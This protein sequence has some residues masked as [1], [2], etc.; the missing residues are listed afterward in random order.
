MVLLVGAIVLLALVTAAEAAVISSNRARLRLLA[1][2]G[3]SRSQILARYLQE[4]H[5][6]YSS[7]ALARNFALIGSTA[8][9]V[10]IVLNE[11]GLN[12]AVL[13]VTFFVA[14]A[15]LAVIQAI[16]RLVVSRN[17][18]RWVAY[19][20]RFVGLVRL[21]F[22]LP[23][24]VLDLP[25]RAI[26][27]WRRL[28]V[29]GTEA[30][31]ETEEILRLLEMEESAGLIDE[32]ERRMIR[33]VMALED[34]TAREIM[35]PR[36]DIVA[37]ASDSSF[38]DIAH[39]IVERGYSRI[40]VFED[41]ID[42]IVGVVYA[43][44]VLDYLANSAKPADVKGMARP[45]YFVPESKKV[46]ELLTE[47]R[48]NK[49]SIA[50]V[51]DE[52]GGT[53]GLVTIEDLIEEIVGEIADEFDVE[54]EPIHRVS[55][56]EAILDARVSIDALQELFGVEVE[57]GDFDTVGGFVFNHL[58][59]MPSVGEEIRVDGLRRSGWTAWLCASSPSAA[60]A[61]SACG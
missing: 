44:A 29:E 40:P 35:V 46:D 17:P 38:E 48:R 28:G 41:T 60:A 24:A 8:I 30:P 56:S 19:L 7:L 2:K 10:Y 4:R 16:P 49:L 25:A 9:V 47:M 32:D 5:T 31:D 34:T 20:A 12:W 13:T 39:V 53:A 3:A 61:S 36:I 6:I 15:G 21:I 14:L 59:K 18:Q 27:R 37:V 26:L 1:G 45:P 22:R 43:R 50:I 57:E 58:G 54:E 55:E 33:K 23:S 51:V 42:N 11:V 52:Y